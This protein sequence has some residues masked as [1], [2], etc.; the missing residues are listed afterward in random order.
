M[1]H[2][3]DITISI[4]AIIGFALVV[5][6]FTSNETTETQE[7]VYGTPE[8]HV[9]EASEITPGG[10]TYMYNKKT[11]EVYYLKAGKKEVSK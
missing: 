5:S 7:I 2:I 8:S 10:S 4:F 9:W 3:K 11:G 6:S 1:K